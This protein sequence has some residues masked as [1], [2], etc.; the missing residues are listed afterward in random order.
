MLAMFEMMAVLVLHEMLCGLVRKVENHQ[1]SHLSQYLLHF[2]CFFAAK[3]AYWKHLEFLYSNQTLLWWDH[4][5]FREKMASKIKDDKIQDLE[6]QVIIFFG[7]LS[8]PILIIDKE[9]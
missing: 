4:L 3:N 2:L 1:Q 6:E 5:F 9:R 7:H 8:Y